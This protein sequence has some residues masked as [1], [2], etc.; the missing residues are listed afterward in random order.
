MTWFT[1]CWF[2]FFLGILVGWILAWWFSRSCDDC[3]GGDVT[4][5]GH[6]PQASTSAPA[7]SHS[8]AP[9]PE[10]FPVPIPLAKT[11]SR[12]E[13]IAAAAAAGISFKGVKNDLQIIEGIG[14]KIAGLMNQDG[15]YTFADLAGTSLE[16][17]GAVLEKAGSRFRLANPGTW[18]EQARLA[19][20]GKWA[21]LKALQDSLDGGIV[22]S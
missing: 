22:K 13:M 17:L 9:A 18:A 15:I 21:E 11:T 20:D 10:S 4:P 8:A 14:P 1:C 6:A 12:A 2:Q 3:S 19:T 5:H 16:K 7:A